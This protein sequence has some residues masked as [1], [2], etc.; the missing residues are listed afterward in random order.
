M[1]VLNANSLEDQWK[2]PMLYSM[3]LLRVEA[4]LQTGRNRKIEAVLA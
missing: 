1:E 3:T 4:I 2:N